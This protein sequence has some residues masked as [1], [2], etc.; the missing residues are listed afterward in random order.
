MWNFPII[1]I[2]MQGSISI[3]FLNVRFYESL[4]YSVE[5]SMT[6]MKPLNLE[7]QEFE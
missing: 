7:K 4:D 2:L 6:E 1:R 5:T 3:F